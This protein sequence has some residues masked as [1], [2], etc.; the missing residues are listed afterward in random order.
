MLVRN[1]SESILFCEGGTYAD[2]YYS[3]PVNA[4]GDRIDVIETAIQDIVSNHPAAPPTTGNGEKPASNGD[5]AQ[6][7]ISSSRGQQR[8]QG[9][10][11]SGDDSLLLTSAPQGISDDSGSTIGPVDS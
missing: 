7:R 3:S 1:R 2:R 8:D 4:M 11:S 6:D 10:A 5:Q 9:D